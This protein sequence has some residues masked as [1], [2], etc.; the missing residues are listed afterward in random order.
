MPVGLGRHPPPPTHTHTCRG[1]LWTW[2]SVHLLLVTCCLLLVTCYLSIVNTNCS[3]NCH[4]GEPSASPPPGYKLIVTT[5]I[6]VAIAIT[7]ISYYCY[8]YY[9]YYYY[10]YYYYYYYI[11]TLLPIITIITILLPINHITIITI[12]LPCC[13]PCCLP[14][15]QVAR[16]LGEMAPD[17]AVLILATLSE[18]HGQAVA[19]ALSQEERDSI[20]KVG[21]RGARL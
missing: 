8:Y 5:V 18:Y 3:P 13:L 15:E 14:P 21:G 4:P 19:E 7:V 2:G 12:L 6:A 10:C 16:I 20:M 11:A 17:E 9:Y 1:A